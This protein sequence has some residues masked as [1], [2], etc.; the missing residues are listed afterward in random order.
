MCP[1]VSA[2]PTDRALLARAVGQQARNLL[3]VPDLTSAETRVLGALDPR[4]GQSCTDVGYKVWGILPNGMTR[5]GPHANAL[6]ARTAGR[7]LR[8]LAAKGLATMRHDDDGRA[9]WYQR[10]QLRP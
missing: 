5:P 2:T 8:R 10:L 9:L 7:V 6:Y 3:R 4:R 1:P